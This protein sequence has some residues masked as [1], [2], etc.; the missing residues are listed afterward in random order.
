M[1]EAV[2]HAHPVRHY[3]LFALLALGLCA[4]AGRVV[5]LQVSD[6]AYLKA[7]GHARHLRA[8]KTPPTRGL[9]LDRNGETLAVSTPVD[10][11]WAH[12]QTLLAEGHALERLAQLLGM[13][14]GEIKELCAKNAEREFVYLKRHLAPQDARRVMDL[15]VPGVELERAYRRYYPLGPVFGQ[16]VGFTNAEDAGQEGLE[17]AFNEPLAGQP[18]KARVLRDR[19]GHT[20]E[21]VESIQP[22]EHGAHLR[23]SLDARLQYLAYRQLAAAV[24]Q[25]RAAGGSF[26]LLDAKSG[27]LLAMVNEPDFNPNNLADREG[28]RF[29][30]RAVTDTLEPGSTLKPFTV[31]MALE[32]G[33]VTP[34][35]RVDTA[36]GTLQIGAHTVR[37]VHDYG[38]LTAARVI[39]KSSNVGVAKI[40]LAQPVAALTEA[41]ARL[42]FGQLTGSGLPGE[43]DGRLPNRAKWQPIEHATLAFGYGMAAT[44]LQLARAYQALANDGVLLPVAVQPVER[45]PAGERVLRAATVR[46]MRAMLEAATGDEGTGGQARVPQ[47]RVAGKTGTVHR[48]VGGQYVSDRYLSVFA[49]MAPATDPRLVAVV[50]INDPR[51]GQHFG[52]QVAAPVF[53]KVVAGALRI[54]NVPPD[55]PLAVDAPRPEGGRT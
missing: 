10:S 24:K 5:Y 50:V 48:N 2:E 51:A 44:P 37:D 6:G 11:V 8:I 52:G 19:V 36:P 29:R 7:Q 32:R 13:R 26:V 9:I 23:L 17:L 42:G 15:H 21:R 3:L 1:D 22:A 25:H 34:D 35:S 46:Q 18:G 47:F 30:N 20:V 45:L 43:V 55:G 4:L 16:V 38:L 33:A 14:A 28:D 31:A 40:A 39:I 49:G 27:E 41:L 54:L 53:S 12:P